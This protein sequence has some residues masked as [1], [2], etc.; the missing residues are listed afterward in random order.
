[1]TRAFWY[2]VWLVVRAYAFTRPRHTIMLDSSP[3]VTRW[4]LTGSRR[5]IREALA[6]GA[7]G[8]PGTYLHRFHRAD[9]DRR[10]HNHP[11]KWCRARILRGG[12]T[13]L[14]AYGNHGPWICEYRAGDVSRIT[15][16]VWH[17]IAALHSE[18]WTLFTA[19][20][21]HGRGWGFR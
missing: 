1:M 12:Y 10:L 11:Y 13:E 7:T 14:Y 16:P 4:Y 19:G 5:K 20:P 18:T 15:P 2:L 8:T 3:Y 17:R 9:A 6:C 21:K